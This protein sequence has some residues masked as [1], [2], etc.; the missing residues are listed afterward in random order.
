M[1][2]HGMHALADDAFTDADYAYLGSDPINNP[3]IDQV[4]MNDGY[5]FSLP[6]NN[7]QY[8]QQQMPSFPNAPSGTTRTAS[9]TTATGGFDFTS[10]LNTVFKGANQY[11]ASQRT[12]VYAPYTGTPVAQSGLFTITPMK[13][14]LAGGIIYLARK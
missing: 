3:P 4:A 2:L 12:P 6:Q 9:G 13:L 11:A 5:T 8:V 14:L 1:Y 7:Q 10:L